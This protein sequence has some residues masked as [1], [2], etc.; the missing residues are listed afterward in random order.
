MHTKICISFQKHIFAT[1]NTGRKMGSNLRI[2]WFILFMGLLIGSCSG[3]TVVEIFDQYHVNITLDG[4]S[5]HVKESL[6][7]KNVID[8]PI[9]PGY[10]YTTLKSSSQNEV[11]GIPIPGK[12]T[13]PIEIKNVKVTFDGKQLNDVLVT[14]GDESTVIR[15]GLWSPISPGGSMTVELEYDSS[16]FVDRG[17]LFTQG[18]Y[19]IAANIPI[20][21]AVINLE[22]QDGSHVTYSNSKSSKSD[23]LTTWTKESLGTDEWLLK[24]EY[25]KLP[26]P[27]SPVRWSL[28]FWLFMLVIV[29]IWSYRN[30]KPRR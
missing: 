23:E 4:D 30:W 27:T 22:L 29:S 17:L 12:K 1:E 6:S 25:S 24:Y 26:L 2:F 28:M 3:E 19:P 16:D 20:N 10:A 15:Y 13:N 18:Y 9:V 5:A 21:N 14:Q 11:F 8:K 7:I